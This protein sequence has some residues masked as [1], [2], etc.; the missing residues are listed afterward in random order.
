LAGAAR[1]AEPKSAVE[2]KKALLQ[3][4]NGKKENSI[5]INGSSQAC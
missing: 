4:R 5:H 2:G 1:A 3:M